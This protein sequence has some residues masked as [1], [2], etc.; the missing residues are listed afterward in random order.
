MFFRLT[1]RLIEDERGAFAVIFGLLAI[2]LVA[3]A[4]AVVDYVT[5]FQA[6]NNTQIALD[7]TALALQPQIYTKS[8]DALIQDAENLVS[9][10]ITDPNI[11]LKIT[12]ASVDKTDGRLQLRADLDIP[13]AFVSL[14]GINNM[15]TTVVSQVTR[16]KLNIEVAFV[17]DNSG[18]MSSSGRLTNLQSATKNAINIL[19]YGTSSPAIGAVKNENTKVAIVP[20]TYFVNVGA[21]HASEFWVDRGGNAQINDD[22]FDDDDDEST[23]FNG[24]V[25]RIALMASLA[26]S[27]YDWKGCFETRVY[28]YAVDDTEPNVY[29]PDTLFTPEFAPDEPGDAGSPKYGF[30]NSYIDDDGGTCTGGTGA[31]WVKTETKLNCWGDATNNADNFNYC[32]NATTAT[33]LLTRADGSTS[34][35]VKYEPYSVDGAAK[36]GCTDAYTGTANE[37][38]WWT[39]Y[40]NRHVRTCTYGA[41]THLSN[42]EL[43][44]RK[45]KYDSATV[46]FAPSA[47][48]EN[49]TQGPNAACPNASLQPLTDDVTALINEVQDMEADGGTNIHEGAAWGFRV[50][51][52]TEPFTEARAY[53]PA[54]SKVMIIMTD[55]E[56]TYWSYDHRCTSNGTSCNTNMNGTYYYMPYGY[57]WNSQSPQYTHERLGDYGIDNGSSMQSNMNGWTSETCENIKNAGIDIFTVGLNPPNQTTRTMLTN[58]A[59]NSGMAYFPSQPSELNTVFASIAE[60]L[61]Q[62]RIER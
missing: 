19:F 23:P 36:I 3:M 53:G 32:G 42:R 18:S 59:S 62:L 34:T 40:N 12:T 61:S 30:N 55:G 48:H 4:G 51:S 28:P 11:K 46:K 49:Y 27:G 17:L 8:T 21:S 33:Y 6:R 29:D 10:R 5:I 22:N 54:T 16:K 47:T 15:K 58:C 60:Q 41:S 43:Q 57:L 37:G 24:S 9:E 31:T 2:V 14:L 20:F 25:D 50:L 44:E 56:N 7:A 1:R 35:S 26:G 39:T 45:C 13:M 38:G 52:P